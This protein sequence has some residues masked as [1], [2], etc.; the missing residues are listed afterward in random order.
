MRNVTMDY[1]TDGSSFV[2]AVT[3]KCLSIR[4]KL[5]PSFESQG[6]ES[7]QMSSAA[8]ECQKATARLYI[9]MVISPDTFDPALS[10]TGTTDF[11][12]I[13]KWACAPWRRI[14]NADATTNPSIDGWTTFDVST[15]TNYLNLVSEPTIEFLDQDTPGSTATKARRMVLSCKTRSAVTI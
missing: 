11:I 2:T 4:A 7:K 8:V 3:V 14:Y 6:S 12:Y 15:N 1:S 5:L 13:Q 9:D 10:T